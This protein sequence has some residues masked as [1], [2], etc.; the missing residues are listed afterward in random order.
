MKNKNKE[1]SEKTQDLKT[2]ILAQA[3]INLHT[4]TNRIKY[5]A[6]GYLMENALKTPKNSISP[7]IK[8]LLE[9][10]AN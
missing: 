3:A 8:F 5:F 9:L 2:D 7:I 1:I 4:H 6:I 10:T